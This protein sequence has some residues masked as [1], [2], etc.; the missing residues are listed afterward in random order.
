LTPSPTVFFISGG[1]AA[2]VTA[3]A[4]VNVYLRPAPMTTFTPVAT[5][6]AGSNVRIVGRGEGGEWV[7]I[8]CAVDGQ[9]RWVR[10]A[11]VAPV[12][13]TL[14]DNAPPSA[15]PNDPRWVPTQAWP[16]DQP[17]PPAATEIPVDDYPMLRH[18]RAN[19]GRVPTAFNGAIQL[20]SNGVAA[21]RITTPPVVSDQLVV[22]ASADHSIYGFNR[23]AGNQAWKYSTFGVVNMPLL[24]QDHMLYYVD[25]EN[26]RAKAGAIQLGNNTPQWLV[27]LNAASYAGSAS[28]ATGFI[29]AEDSLYIGVKANDKYYIVRMDRAGGGTLAAFEVGTL[30]PVGMAVGHQLLYVAGGQLWALDLD[31]LEVIW[32]R[33]D[34]G[35]P[36]VAPLYAANG[37][38]ALAELYL[39]FNDG[40]THALD[41]NTGALLHSYGGNG[42]PVK[43]LALGDGALYVTTAGMI[44]AF[45][46]RSSGLYWEKATA[47]DTLNGAIV[48]PDQL[49]LVSNN[50]IIEFLQPGTGNSSGRYSVNGAVNYAPAVSGSYIFVPVDNNTGVGQVY[51]YAQ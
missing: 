7:Y 39:A 26:G 4:G 20:F 40:R 15:T 3:A 18:D 6:V 41:A 46:R 29:A 14:P 35:N 2:R 48:S 25:D 28:A 23:S 27:D 9:Q 1:L 24:V 11:Y 37:V 45:E 22:V 38:S 34:L 10:L 30:P 21:G 19:T 47:G 13:N 17:Q 33:A 49:I 50:G 31:T 16:A 5:L 36:A 43:G 8:C 12:D 51:G 42:Q 32:S 44:R